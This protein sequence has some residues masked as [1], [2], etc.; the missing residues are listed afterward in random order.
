MNKLEQLEHEALEQEIEVKQADFPSTISG[1]YCADGVRKPIIGLNKLLKTKAE[2]CCILAE[3]LGH[4]YTSYGNL[5]SDPKI[6]KVIVRQQET[7]AKR[8][9]TKKLVPLKQLIQAFEAGC[10]NT[11]E[12]AEFLEI[13]EEFLWESYKNYSQIYGSYKTINNYVLYFDPPAI[14]KL[15]I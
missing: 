2:T 9:A 10:R 6:D 7:R 11:Y 5:L 12:T 3:E 1:L 13:T 15:I 8:W 14:L 4:Y